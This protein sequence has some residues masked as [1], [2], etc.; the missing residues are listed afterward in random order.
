M[1]RLILAP[2][3]FAASV[4]TAQPTDAVDKGSFG[5]GLM[6]GEPV[7]LTARLYVSDDQA[8]NAG[9]G[10]ALVAG[11]LQVHADYVFHPWII[12]THEEFILPAYLGP[13]LR[14]AQYNARDGFDSYSA[15]GVRVVAGMVFDFTRVPL[16]AF[17]EAAVIPELRFRDSTKFG[18]AVN[19]T[20]G[21]RYY[22]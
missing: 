5:L 6:I 9:L 21:V 4:A 20:A 3:C 12:V 18:L 8:I 7:G 13:G 1:N 19:G 17:I 10:S 11:G 15:I 14:V 16:D 22:F 2:L